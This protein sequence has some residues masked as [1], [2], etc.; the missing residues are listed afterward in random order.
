MSFQLTATLNGD[1]PFTQC[2]STHRRSD[3]CAAGL[4][5]GAS[6]NT[7][8]NPAD[9]REP[10]WPARPASRQAPQPADAFTGALVPRLRSQWLGLHCHRLCFSS[11]TGSQGLVARSDLSHARSPKPASAHCTKCVL[12]IKRKRAKDAV[13]SGRLPRRMSSK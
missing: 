10:R 2:A 4:P 3:A 8:S 7:N 9:A 11:R 5:H 13:R 1:L 6:T 12:S